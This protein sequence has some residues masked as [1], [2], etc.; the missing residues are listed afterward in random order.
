MGM[1]PKLTKW[2]PKV[3]WDAAF[4]PKDLYDQ[5]DSLPPALIEYMWP[6]GWMFVHVSERPTTK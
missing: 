3:V 1:V 2:G 6:K 4:Q 5:L